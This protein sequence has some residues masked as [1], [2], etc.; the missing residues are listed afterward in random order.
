MCSSEPNGVRKEL[1]QSTTIYITYHRGE[2]GLTGLLQ[3]WS[4]CRMFGV[5]SSN[6]R[7]QI[8]FFPI[9]AIGWELSNSWQQ[10]CEAA[11]TPGFWQIYSRWSHAAHTRKTLKLEENEV[12]ESQKSCWHEE[13]RD[14]CSEDFC[15]LQT[16]EWAVSCL[17]SHVDSHKSR[18]TAG[19]V[20]EQRAFH[21]FPVF[22]WCDAG[23]RWMMKTFNIF[24]TKYR[25]KWKLNLVVVLF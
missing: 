14:L 9:E 17:W 13:S 20:T 24:P 7:T 12:I 10:S 22:S 19:D 15:F 2:T 3:C 6:E 1:S 16:W 5:V 23:S 11:W 8:L 4:T 21:V 18:F 25:K